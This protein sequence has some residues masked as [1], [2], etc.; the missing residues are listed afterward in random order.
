MASQKSLAPQR[1]QFPYTPTS[2]LSLFHHFSKI[3]V[4]H[5]AAP[6]LGSLAQCPQD[7]PRLA[8][9]HGVCQVSPCKISITP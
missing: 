4:W 6:N 5:Q 9:P 2:V 3:I 8:W 1:L 7:L